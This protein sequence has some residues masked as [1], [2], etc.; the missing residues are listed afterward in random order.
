MTAEEQ[1]KRITKL[2]NDMDL[3]DVSYAKFEE[4]FMKQSINDIRDELWR[5][6]CF[7]EDVCITLNM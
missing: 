1:I 2:L 6:Y 4:M 5:M 7:T 3:N